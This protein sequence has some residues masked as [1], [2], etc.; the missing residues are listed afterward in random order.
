[1]NSIQKVA[2]QI[3]ILSR[4]LFSYR[5]YHYL[6]FSIYKG[7]QHYLFI[8]KA[9]QRFP[10][11]TLHDDLLM[12]N[13]ERVSIGERCIISPGCYFNC[14]FAPYW[15]IINMGSNITVGY[16]ECLY[17]GGG[18][19]IIGNHV[20]LGIN[21][22]ITTQTRSMTQHPVQ[23]RTNFE[24]HFGEVI[25][26]E[27]TLVASNVTL[28]AGT[29]LGKYCNVVAGAVVQGNYPDNT[30]LVGNPA[31]PVPRIEIKS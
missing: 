24:H 13:P 19:I 15:G 11:T 18:K 31:R 1:M 26:G 5:F 12:P 21:C 14:G 29:T 7:F 22:I 17:A 16:N 3:R 28:L 27:G 2:H 30:T 10:N 4:T 23:N 20:D 9:K 6:L 8:A 25:V